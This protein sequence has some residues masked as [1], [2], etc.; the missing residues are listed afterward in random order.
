M[1]NH[2]VVAKELVRRFSNTGAKTLHHWV[3]QQYGRVVSKGEGHTTLDN[4]STKSV[5]NEI[6]RHLNCFS[7]I[8]PADF[9]RWFSMV[10]AFDAFGRTQASIDALPQ[11][12]QDVLLSANPELTF[13]AVVLRGND[14][15]DAPA[16]NAPMHYQTTTQNY[17]ADVRGAALSMTDGKRTATLVIPEHEVKQIIEVHKRTKFRCDP[18]DTSEWNNTLIAACYRRIFHFAEAGQWVR[19]IDPAM[20]QSL[21]LLE[22]ELYAIFNQHSFTQDVKDD[23]SGRLVA[24]VAEQFKPSA[25]DHKALLASANRVRN[26]LNLP[27]EGCD[28]I[29]LALESDFLAKEAEKK[30]QAEKIAA[31]RNVVSFGV[32]NTENSTRAEDDFSDT[33]WGTF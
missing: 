27:D 12:Y 5:F 24:T 19:N 4:V 32:V 26:A 14:L 22:T 16:T 8:K 3:R 17:H 7:S 2:K 33:E 31:P 13:D 10:P 28:A 23:F 15:I 25:D 29:V 9:I 21:D 1:T 20:M 11:L 30:K 18:L 6:E